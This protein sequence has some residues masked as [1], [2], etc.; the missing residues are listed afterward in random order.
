ME[1]EIFINFKHYDNAVGKNSEK[2]LN[3]FNS[4]RN[5]NGLYY[6]ISPTDLWLQKSFPSLKIFGQHVDSN[7]YGAYT[8]SISMESMIDIG[9]K[10]SLLNHSEKRIGSTAIEETV[11]KSKKLDFEIV[12]CVEDLHEVE[13]YSNL[14]PAYIA[15]EPPELIGGNVSVSSA[16]PEIIA[17]AAKA[18]NGKTKLLVGAGVKTRKDIDISMDLGASGVLIASGIIRNAKP[19]NMLVSLSSNR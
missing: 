17:Q 19:I 2:L 8:G 14:E 15:Y 7:S 4:I 13:K 6:C 9:I 16:K 18:C 3:D 10:G 1:P 12:L 11:K 5:Q